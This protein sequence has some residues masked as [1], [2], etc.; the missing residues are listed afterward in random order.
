MRLFY[1]AAS[2]YV[3][4]VLV[5]ADEVGMRDAIELVPMARSLTKLQRQ[6]GAGHGLQGGDRGGSIPPLIP[7][8]AGTQMA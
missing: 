6:A 5:C 3:R 1:S 7:A 8:T 4:K 2:P